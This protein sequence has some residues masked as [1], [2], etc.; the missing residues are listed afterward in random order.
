MVRAGDMPLP[1]TL[2]P[3]VAD[4]KEKPRS[5][6][7]GSLGKVTYHLSHPNTILA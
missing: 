4:H 5:D 3:P 6:F 7:E 1:L 2:P